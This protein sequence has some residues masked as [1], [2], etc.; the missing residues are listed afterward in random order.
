MSK[1][2]RKNHP[3]KY[4]REEDIHQLIGDVQLVKENIQDIRDNHLATIH[5]TLSNL[6]GR[7]D[8]LIPIV[9]AILTAI[10]GLAVYNLIP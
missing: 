9:I 1:G 8:I 10:I 7:L 5:K 6:Q 3:R 2:N 4:A